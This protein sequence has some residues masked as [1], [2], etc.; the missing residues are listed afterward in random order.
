[1][2]DLSFQG[3]RLVEKAGVARTMLGIAGCAVVGLA[4]LGG[5]SAAAAQTSRKDVAY[6]MAVSGHASATA[7]G[8]SADLD[9]LDIIYQGTQVDLDANAELRLC[10]YRLRK[11]V[12]LKGPLHAVISATGIATDQGDLA[13]SAREP[14]TAPAV[15]TIQGGVAYRALLQPTQ[16][17]LNPS[18]K[19]LDSRSRR[20]QKAMILDE[21]RHATT[22]SFSHG[23]AKP[24]L[25]DGQDYSLVV[26]LNDGRKWRLLLRASAAADNSVVILVTQ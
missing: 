7:E 8:N 3:E 11:L 24:Q 15:S 12:T 23:V 1:M 2:C 20:I 10:H 4:M 14:C 16:V 6:V 26:E 13:T 18:I 17:G 21:G 9:G 25:T 19:L 5:V 22:V